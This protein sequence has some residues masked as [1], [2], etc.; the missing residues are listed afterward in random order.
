MTTNVALWEEVWAQLCRPN[1]C[2][3]LLKAL[4]RELLPYCNQHMIWALPASPKSM[5]PT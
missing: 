1:T 2:V 4:I 3:S 5:L